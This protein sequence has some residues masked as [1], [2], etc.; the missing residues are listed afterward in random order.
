MGHISLSPALCF[1]DNFGNENSARSFSVQNVLD[2]P[3]GRG[4]PCLRVMDVRTEVLVFPRFKDP[5]RNFDPGY[6]R[7]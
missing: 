3:Q 1:T 5:D 2:T 7:E 4:R 6:P